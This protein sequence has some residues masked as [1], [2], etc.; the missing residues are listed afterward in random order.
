MGIAMA[1]PLTQ[2]VAAQQTAVPPPI[3]GSPVYFIAIE[4]QQTGPYDLQSLS[5][6]IA[7]GKLS[8]QT[9]VWTE[10]MASWT[11]AGQVPILEKL[12][13][14]TPPPIPQ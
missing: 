9:L 13:A 14:G 10:G 2:A 8:R 7:S 12:F 3:P 5:S 6:Q 1:G 11:P 4:G